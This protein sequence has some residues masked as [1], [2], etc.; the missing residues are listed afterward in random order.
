[1]LERCE[2]AADAK[3]HH[4]GRHEAQRRG[5]RGAAEQRHQ[6]RERLF[7]VD[8]LAREDDI[9][10]VVECVRVPA[11]GEEAER[12]AAPC[13]VRLKSTDQLVVNVE[14]ARRVQLVRVKVPCK[15]EIWVYDQREDFFVVIT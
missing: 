12:D 14:L 11:T 2:A 10:L 6:T 5:V 15:Q 7:G 3:V 1:M 9:E 8:G 13:E 4:L